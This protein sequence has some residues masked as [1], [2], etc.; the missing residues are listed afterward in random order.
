MQFVFPLAMLFVWLFP[1]AMT[2]RGVVLEKESRL[3][4]YIKM[5]GVSDTQLNLSKIIVSGDLNDPSF[6]LGLDHTNCRILHVNC[7]AYVQLQ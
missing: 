5:V 3:K 1:V 2:V 7:I 4:E 6:M